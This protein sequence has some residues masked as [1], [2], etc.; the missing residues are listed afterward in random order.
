MLLPDLLRRA[1]ARFPDKLAIHFPDAPANTPAAADPAL[2][3]RISFR[4]L[5]EASDR[6]ARRLAALGV[7]PGD[8][9][10]IVS[11]NA[12][13]AYTFF[14]G[15]LKSGAESVDL[16]AQAGAATLEGV[17]EEARPKAV[18]VQAR[19]LGKIFEG[20]A[21]PAVYPAHLVT[22]AD[23]AAEATKLGFTVTTLEGT[24]A[25]EPAEFAP[26]ELSPDAVAMIVYTSGTTGRPKGVML[27]HD[28]LWSNISSA[29]GWVGLTDADSI[30]LVVP[31]YFVHGRMQILT[32]MMIAG[33]IFVSAG[34]QF[35]TVVLNELKKYAVTGWSGVP[36]HFITLMERTKVKDAPPP[37][38]EYV[39]V[40]GGAL[41]LAHLH[42]L[43]ATLPGVGIHTAYGQTEASPRITW[44][45]PDDMFGPKKGSAGK[46]LPGVRVD[47]V[48][49]EGRALPA[50]QVG[51]VAA[52]GPNIMKGY[53]SGDHV[54]SGRID[55]EG[56][57]R[58]GDLGRIDE[59]GFLW[60]VGRSSDMIKS[61]GE[62][63]FPKEVEDVI[64]Q[65]PAV[66]ECA[67]IGVKDPTLGEKISAIVALREGHTLTL[68]E[69]RSF[70]LKLLPFVR[71][72]RDLRV[73]AA[74]PKTA[75][76]KINRG[77]LQDLWAATP[78]S[79][80]K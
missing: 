55:A 72:P 9:V 12:P 21:R 16:P 17:V 70:C 32:H 30:L 68:N 44:L 62:R 2:S 54:S 59:D 33:T 15:V 49:G 23:G 4:Q 57:L 76:G 47:I 78:D 8:R 48:D 58:T 28:N 25:T 56:R 51:E 22:T 75:S 13:E 29:N 1:A 80:H 38:L 34:F 74:L 5:D 61:A 37:A 35:P 42:E 60:L 24:L 36:Y 31:F 40:T 20:G 71:A 6:I 53:V 46:P 77:G 52:A 43:H 64:L 65:H 67:V 63:V 73:V 66:A 50:G 11:E 3:T 41:S 79:S 39:L 69:L 19:L 10:G 27:S 14:W 45:G 7:G 26:L 18:F